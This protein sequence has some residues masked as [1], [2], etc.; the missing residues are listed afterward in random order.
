[1]RRHRSSITGKRET[2]ASRIP[3]ASWY[4]SSIAGRFSWMAADKLALASRQR[5]DVFQ[6]MDEKSGPSAR[7]VFT[8]FIHLL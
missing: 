3:P 5:V 8:I 6:K 7:R 4:N 1:M 2:R